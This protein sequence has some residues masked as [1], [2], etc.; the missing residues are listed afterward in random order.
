MGFLF[1]FGGRGLSFL[2][3]LLLSS[4]VVVVV[5]VVFLW[6][7]C[8]Y[9]F[10]VLLF[11]FVCLFVCFFVFVCVCVC[12]CVLLFLWFVCYSFCWC[13]VV[14][15]CFLF[16]VKW[17]FQ[18]TH[19]IIFR[20]SMSSLE[21]YQKW[22]GKPRLSRGPCRHTLSQA[23]V[24]VPSVSLAGAVTGGNCR[25]YHFCRDKHVTNICRDKHTFVGTKDVFCLDKNAVV[26]PNDGAERLGR[27][28]AVTCGLRLARSEVLMSLGKLPEGTG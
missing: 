20:T 28:E 5:V 27:K 2:L 15:V 25:K 18:T 11:L 8:Y 26:K 21:K 7:V 9:F 6:F 10:V 12:V 22:N 13:F 4:F 16:L 19:A 24:G 23:L 1:C 3:L 17:K 14:F